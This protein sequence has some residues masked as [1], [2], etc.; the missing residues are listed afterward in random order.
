MEYI[1]LVMRIYFDVIK[2]EY[3][4]LDNWRNQKYVMAAKFAFPLYDFRKSKSEAFAYMQKAMIYEAR[5]W[6]NWKPIYNLRFFCTDEKGINA[7][8]YD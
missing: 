2:K 1:H 7:Y 3:P 6:N 5:K 8:Y 4:E